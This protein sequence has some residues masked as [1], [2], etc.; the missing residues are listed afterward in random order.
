MKTLSLKNEFHLH[1]NKKK[2]FHIND[3]ALNLALKQRLGEISE[4]H[5]C[6]GRTG[7]R[8]DG[9]TVTQ[10]PNFFECIENQFF[11]PMVLGSVLRAR[12]N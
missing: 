1:D 10:L 12:E 4:I 8:V 11:L 2:Q 6:C 5:V 3:I 9:R 7:E